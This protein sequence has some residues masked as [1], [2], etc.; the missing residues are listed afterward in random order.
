MGADSNAFTSDDLTVYH[1]LAGKQALPKIVE[2]EADRFQNLKYKEAEF[3]KEA[4]RRPGEY[5]KSASN[6]LQKMARRS[7]TTPSR[8]H[9]QAHDDRLSARHRGHAEPVRLLAAVLRALLPPRQRRALDRRT[10]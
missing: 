6:P 10:T 9:V 5:N 1:I 7:T 2:I 3:Q 8:P 4:A